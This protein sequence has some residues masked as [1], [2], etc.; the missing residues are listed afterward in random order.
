MN[1]NLVIVARNEHVQR[2]NNY[3]RAW[4]VY[5]RDHE[6]VIEVEHDQDGKPLVRIHIAV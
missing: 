3:P 6:T 5:H 1:E 4:C 2:E